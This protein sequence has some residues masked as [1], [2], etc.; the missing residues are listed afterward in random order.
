MHN[1]VTEGVAC[2]DYCV[3]DD[4]VT[5]ASLYS[6]LRHY[7]VTVCTI[8]LRKGLTVFTIASRMR[9][10]CVTVCTIASLSGHCIH[11]RV[12][13]RVDCIHYCV[14][15]DHVTIALL[16]SLPRHYHVTVCT[17]ASPSRHCI[18]YRVTEGLD[19]I[20][21]CVMDD[22]V[23]VVYHCVTITSLYLLSSHGWGCLYAPSRHYRVTVCTAVSLLRH[24]IHNRVH[25]STLHH[26]GTH[27]NT[28]QHT[29]THCNTL[30]HTATH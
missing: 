10:Y 9:H 29:A 19:C 16:Y 27:C 7:R 24:F 28:L 25:C 8:A 26:T 6:L 17:I 20:H 22:L 11:Y 23:S 15:D 5:M 2:V 4:C 21:Y 1:R 12:M 3:T 18:H 13:E 30:Q 14:T